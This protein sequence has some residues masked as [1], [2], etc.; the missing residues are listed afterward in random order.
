MSRPSEQRVHEAGL[1]GV[2]AEPESSMEAS[3]VVKPQQ[4]TDGECPS[5]LGYVLTR[6]KCEDRTPEL[7][8]NAN[9]S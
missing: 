4:R 9:V 2:R 5:V 3:S 8:V 7:R 1:A 6:L